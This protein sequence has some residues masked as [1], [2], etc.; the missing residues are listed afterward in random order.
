MR[1]RL[2]LS[3]LLGSLLTSL[4]AFVFVHWYVGGSTPVSFEN[5]SGR[6][7]EALSISGS[8][9]KASLGEIRPGETIRARV[10]PAGESTI[11]IA[12]RAN[13][14]DVSVPVDVY[15]EGGGGYRLD[16]SVDANL[17]ASVVVD[18]FSRRSLLLP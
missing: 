2:A 1:L 3:F 12:F 11:H 6:L 8:G 7:L 5:Q 9:F 14:R 16:I 4:L 13:G 18:A 10:F 15:F 17:K